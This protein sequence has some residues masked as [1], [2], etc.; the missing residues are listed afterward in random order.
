MNELRE[1]VG[2]FGVREVVKPKALADTNF[3][4][5]KFILLMLKVHSF[6][7][8]HNLKFRHLRISINFGTMLYLLQS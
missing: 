6:L 5:I 8:T 3:H 7:T 1:V 2:K 4:L